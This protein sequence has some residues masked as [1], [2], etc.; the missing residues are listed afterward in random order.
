MIETK[1]FS[2]FLNTDDKPENVAG[3]QHIDA[4]NIRF[5]GGPSGLTAENVKGNYIINNALLPGGTNE[6]IG[7]FY[8]SVNQIIIWFNYNSNLVKNT[9]FNL[10]DHSGNKN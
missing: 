1:R 7:T 10:K 2:G 5:Y 4:K 9:I 6:C 3:A 8:D